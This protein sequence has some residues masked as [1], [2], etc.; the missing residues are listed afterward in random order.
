MRLWLAKIFQNL[1][2]FFTD[3]EERRLKRRKE[4]YW[5]RVSRA[6]HGR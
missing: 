5:R 1:E 2:K 3:A 6:W 4:N